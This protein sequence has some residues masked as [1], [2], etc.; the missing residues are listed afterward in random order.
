MVSLPSLAAKWVD[1]DSSTRWDSTSRREPDPRTFEALELLITKTHAAGGVVHIWYVGDC[2]RA[3]CAQAGFGSNGARSEEEKRLLRYIGARFGPL[4]G[5]I[6]GYGYDNPEHVDT[7]SLRLWGNYLRDYMG[8]SHYLG[9]RN[10][11]K[12]SYTFWPEA[13]FFSWGNLDWTYAETCNALDQ[14]INKP[15]SLDERFWSDRLNMDQQHRSLWAFTMAGGASAIWAWDTPGGVSTSYPNPEQLH[16]Y[17]KFWKDRFLKEIVRANNLTEGWCLWVP[18]STNYIFYDEDTSSIQMDL[19]GMAEAQQ[20]VAVNTKIA[21]AEIDL[22]TL[23]PTNQTWTA[24]YSSDWAIAVGGFSKRSSDTAP[25]TT[26]QSLGGIA[27][28][29]F[30]IDL[31]WQAASDPESGISGYKV[32]RDGTFIGQSSTTSFSD[33]GLTENTI[34]VYEVSAVNGAGLQSEKS[35]PISVTTLAETIDTIAPSIISA[36]TSGDPNKVTVVFS[37]PVEEAS[38]EDI[39]NYGIDNDVTISGASLASDLKTVVFANNIRD[40]ASTPNVIAANTQVTYAFAGQ[41]VIS[42]LTVDSGKAYEVIE[43]G[44][45]SGSLVYIDRIYT[46]KDVPAS[47]LGATYIKTAN[48]DKG[49]TGDSFMS[50]DVNQDV[51]VYVAH[52]NRIATKPSWMASF[53]DTGDDLVTTDATLSIFAKHVSA[54]TVTLGGNEGGGCSMYIAIIVAQGTPLLTAPTGLSIVSTE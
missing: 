22:G 10:Q 19:S 3:Q 14:E 17:S 50:F 29:E 24:P 9:A 2:S 25:P 44:L 12:T 13:D 52:D 43:N 20:A 21:Y 33:T 11:S 1:I 28:S 47:L 40:R 54:G 16:T 41:L 48:A 26:P 38:S 4:P 7:A 18:D 6:M 23:N 42:N 30:R 34:Y 51:T 53:T 32:Y 39:S 8:W 46:F 15:H 5:W 31:A 27:I 35:A 45:Q 37:E 49:L 36:T